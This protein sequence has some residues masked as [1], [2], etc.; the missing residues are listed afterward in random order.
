MQCI[1]NIYFVTKRIKLVDWR[2]SPDLRNG[3]LPLRETWPAGF[4]SE[5]KAGHTS[6]QEGFKVN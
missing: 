6:K 2:V 5:G 4:E 1:K 3:E